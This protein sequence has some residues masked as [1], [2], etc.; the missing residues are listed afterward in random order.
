MGTNAPSAQELDCKEQV[1]ETIEKA[2]AAR[3]V[4]ASR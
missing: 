3:G 2:I 4:S 1:D